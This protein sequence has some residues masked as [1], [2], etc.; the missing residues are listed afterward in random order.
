[1]ASA[2][3]NQLIRQVFQIEHLL[4]NI[5]E[6]VIFLNTNVAISTQVQKL[7]LVSKQWYV[8]VD[9]LLYRHNRESS[10]GVPVIN[11][12]DVNKVMDFIHEIQN[13]CQLDEH[14]L[15]FRFQVKQ[16]FKRSSIAKSELVLDLLSEAGAGLVSLELNLSELSPTDCTTFLG[17][18]FPNL[19]SLQ[20]TSKYNE[21][22]RIQLFQ[23]V[24]SN[25][26]ILSQ[27]KIIFEDISASEETLALP[28]S[29]NDFQIEMKSATP[30]SL[31]RLHGFL[32]TNLRVFQN[33][34]RLSILYCEV[35]SFNAGKV[36]L[37]LLPCCSVNLDQ[38][39][40]SK[41]N[42]TGTD[43]VSLPE[44]SQFVPHMTNLS[45]LRINS[46]W[47]FQIFCSR[48]TKLMSLWPN[49][50]KLSLELHSRDQFHQWTEMH[51]S[52]TIKELKLF[53]GNSDGPGPRNIQHMQYS[54]PNLTSL[55]IHLGRLTL[56]Q[57][58]AGVVVIFQQ[59]FA[60]Q[61]LKLILQDGRNVD[62]DRVFTG[63]S[64][65]RGL[66]DMEGE[67][68]DRLALLQNPHATGTSISSMQS[69]F[70]L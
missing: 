49:L 3:A 28:N 11:I 20:I 33:I 53:I 9:S 8:T 26:P 61:E 51:P 1:M 47:A 65:P 64:S 52:S 29:V 30:L 66:K 60:L 23:A 40:V 37:K 18:Y 43:R 19:K 35:N 62:W 34:R 21:S 48:P 15:P 50:R 56:Q 58:C 39:E 42:K 13:N 70:I 7:R 6:N 45:E 68:T 55:T 67:G 17:F 36:I 10:Y 4:E 46:G 59:L 12:S 31:D 22:F 63:T 16:S 57:D 27:V 38:L 32:R 41:I 54:Y 25:S 24:L 14:I 44:S 2:K 5:I 69:N